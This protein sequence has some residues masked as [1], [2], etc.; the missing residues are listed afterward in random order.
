MNEHFLIA[1]DGSHL[2]IYTRYAAPGQRT[3]RR[4][5][6]Y[7]ADFPADIK[8][9]TRHDTDQAGRF[10]SSQSQA[11]G[12]GT[13]TTGRTG[14]S[15]DERL[16]MRE[17]TEARRAHDLA[18]QIESFLRARP[19]ASWDFAA[20]PQ[21]NHAILE[22]LSP[23]VRNRLKSSVAKNLIHELEANRSESNSPFAR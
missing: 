7:A 13:N 4:E 19:D 22:R 18:A 2:R 20:G 1:A 9:Y 8:R 21:W 5:Q 15:I 23:G 10:Q 6:V 16:P 17:E 14:M 12:P 3:P 11:A